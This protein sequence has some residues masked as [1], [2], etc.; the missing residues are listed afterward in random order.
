[1]ANTND[2]GKIYCY[3]EFGDEDFT[4]KAIYRPSCP[5]CFLEKLQGQFIET[6]AL[7]VDTIRYRVS[8]ILFRADQTT[9]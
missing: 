1:M 7:T 5:S 3:T 2:W 8:S 4:A 9:V 6:L